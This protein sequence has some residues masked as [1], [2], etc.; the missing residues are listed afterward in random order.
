MTAATFLTGGT[1][2]NG[3]Q[4]LG[5]SSSAVTGGSSE[6]CVSTAMKLEFE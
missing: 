6:A 3:W 1:A 5:T 2:P 4:T